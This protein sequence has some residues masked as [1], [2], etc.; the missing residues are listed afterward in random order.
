[1][2]KDFR[3][4]AQCIMLFDRLLSDRVDNICLANSC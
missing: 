4:Y 3:L 2:S 1:M